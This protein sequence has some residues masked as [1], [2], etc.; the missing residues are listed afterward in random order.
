MGMDPQQM[1]RMA[2][3]MQK[4]MQQIDMSALEKMKTRAE[5]MEREISSL[6]KNGQRNKAMEKGMAFAREINKTPE[7]VKMR[8]CTSSMKG[9]MPDLSHYESLSKDKGKH[10]HICDDF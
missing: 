5:N 7:L 2:S 1:Q 3:Q 6:C 4:C 8:K 10:S 9:M